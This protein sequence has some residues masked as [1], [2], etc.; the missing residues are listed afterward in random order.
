MVAQQ[1]V[2]EERLVAVGALVRTL[3]FV[4]EHVVLLVR[5]GGERHRTHL[6]HEGFVT[7]VRPQVQDHAR[8]ALKHLVAGLARAAIIC[9]ENR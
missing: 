4:A 6:A 3:H 2:S 5:V 1:V 8:L 7:C 9:R